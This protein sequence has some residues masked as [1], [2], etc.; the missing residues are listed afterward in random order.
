MFIYFGSKFLILLQ[1]IHAGFNG[2]VY[3]SCSLSSIANAAVILIS[4]PFT[5]KFPAT[6]EHAKDDRKCSSAFHDSTR[7]INLQTEHGVEGDRG[8][9]RREDK[10]SY[11]GNSARAR[12]IKRT[13]SSHVAT[14][15]SLP[16]S[17]SSPCVSSGIPVYPRQLPK[18]SITYSGIRNIPRV[19]L[20][21]MAWDSS[22]G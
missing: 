7:R 11:K 15:P 19:A 5:R 2:S 22:F 9:N 18:F 6:P 3:Y 13:A 16:L 8:W 21:E 10:L 1:I 17:L 14:C 12:P 20:T 4:T